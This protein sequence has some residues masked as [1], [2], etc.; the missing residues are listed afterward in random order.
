MSSASRARPTAPRA[1]QHGCDGP[2]RGPTSH[3]AGVNER[4]RG[5]V[6]MPGR[7]V[8]TR[9]LPGAQCQPDTAHQ[10]EPDGAGPRPRPLRLLSTREYASGV[11]MRPLGNKSGARPKFALPRFWSGPR[12]PLL[13]GGSGLAGQVVSVL[14][15]A[16]S[17][18]NVLAPDGR[19]A[20]APHMFS[21]TFP[22]ITWRTEYREY[23]PTHKVPPRDS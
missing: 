7:G 23:H 10:T 1:P 19:L 20:T 8:T 12:L 3:D 2:E 15:P 14:R 18:L 21:F 17:R 6:G 4:P 11:K 22:D 9:G 5:D 16:R 13:G